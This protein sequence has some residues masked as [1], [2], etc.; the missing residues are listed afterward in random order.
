MGIDLVSVTESVVVAVVVQRV[1]RVGVQFVI[2]VESVVVGIGVQRIGAARVDLVSVAESVVVRICVEWVRL[3]RV[4]RAVAVGV[5]FPVG[6]A[7]IVG[8]RPARVR[9]G[10]LFSP[11]VQTVAVGVLGVVRYTV[12]VGVGPVRPGPGKVFI[13]IVELVTIGVEDGIAGV[14]W[15]PAV[16]ELPEVGQSVAIGVGLLV[17]GGLD[18]YGHRARGSCGCR[19]AIADLVGERVGTREVEVDGGVEGVPVHDASVGH[20]RGDTGGRLREDAIES[21]GI[22]IGVEVVVEYGDQH[23]TVI[24]VERRLIVI[25]CRRVRPGGDGDAH[26][27]GVCVMGLTV[28]HRVAEVVDPVEPGVRCI[29]DLVPGHHRRA[30]VRCVRDASVWVKDDRAAGDRV[31]R[32]NVDGDRDTP[33]GGRG[34]VRRIGGGCRYRQAEEDG[35]GTDQRGGSLR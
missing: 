30:V 17:P 19:I 13:E 28:S 16:A 34:V 33:G 27:A 31:V 23:G 3:S 12:A 26:G 18:R 22:A 20:D 7:V 14:Q 24:G 25:G 32:Q 4:L 9:P 6:K 1:G 35:L 5:L 21:D 11:V 29:D 15:V 2:V 8:V 10:L